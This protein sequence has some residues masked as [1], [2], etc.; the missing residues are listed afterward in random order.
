MDRFPDALENSSEKLPRSGILI[1]LGREIAFK[2]SR[3]QITQRRV[4]AFAV[5][6]LFEELVN[7]CA[8]VAQM[9]VFVAMHLFVL[10][11]FHE[12]FA[13]G[14]VPRIRS[15]THADIDTVVLQQT[16]V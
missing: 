7:G 3:R 1:L 5:V 13:R 6:D 2:L 16:C 14:V 4:K 8:S 10:Q 11:S 15:A 12:G 9:P